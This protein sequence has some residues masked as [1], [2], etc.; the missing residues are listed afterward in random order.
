MGGAAAAWADDEPE[1]SPNLINWVNLDSDDED[2]FW[3][4]LVW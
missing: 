1:K 3:K 2:P 4:N